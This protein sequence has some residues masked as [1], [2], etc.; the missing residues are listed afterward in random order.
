MEILI[1]VLLIGLLAAVG[2]SFKFLTDDKKELTRVEDAKAKRIADL[3][4]DLG[5]KD[6]E[7]KKSLGEI[8]RIEDAYY[9]AKNDVDVA[10]KEGSELSARL[11]QAE[12]AREEQGQAKDEVKLKAAALEQETVARQK[13]QGQLAMADSEA[14]KAKAKVSELEKKVLDLQADLKAKN[15][16]LEGLKGQFSELEAEVQKSGLK[17]VEKSKPE[18]PKSEPPKVEPVKAE[19]PKPQPP[20]AEPPKSEPPKIESPKPQPPKVEP[21]KSEPPKIESP[22][23]Q[24]SKVEPPKPE[25]PKV[26]PP[27]PQPPKVEPPKVEPP[28]P[29]PPKVEPPKVEPPKPEPPKVE[30]PKPEP[31]KKELKPA[32]PIDFAPEPSDKSKGGPGV[33]FTKQE[34]KGGAPSDTDFLKAGPAPKKADG[35]AGGVPEGAFKITNVNKPAPPSPPSPP[36]KKD[37]DVK[38]K[39][40]DKSKRETLIPGFHPKE[41]N[42]PEEPQ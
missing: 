4:A 20:K 10:K 7:L 38:D 3:E 12:K 13:L 41:K 33:G 17:A 15:E 19:P 28:K 8:Q 40:K 11:K 18:S 36:P 31:P 29:Q 5:R 32:P 35:L 9:Q 37:A 42:S 23:P 21:P 39:A 34:L 26:E 2:L 25:P 27:K 1:G 22:K 16:T 14:E 6:A 24:P 30:P